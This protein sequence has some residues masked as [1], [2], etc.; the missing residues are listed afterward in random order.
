MFNIA[1]ILIIEIK[2]NFPLDNNLITNK[3][4]INNISATV[5]D[6]YKRII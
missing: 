2:I 6:K 1:W 3:F 4:I 5:F